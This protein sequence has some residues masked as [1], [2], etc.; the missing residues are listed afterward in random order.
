M[1]SGRKIAEEYAARVRDWIAERDAQGDYEDYQRDRKVNRTTLCAE[2]DFGRSVLT[3]N[4][5]VKAQLLEAEQRWYGHG[6]KKANQDHDAARE[7]AERK[8]TLTS[9][10]LSTALD[11][12]AKLRAENAHL[13]RKLRK[14]ETL[15]EILAETGRLPRP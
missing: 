15:E 13:R 4:P 1:P 10:E 7:R 8:S 12:N 11:E 14:Y 2:L 9:R 5:N 3:Q 6:E